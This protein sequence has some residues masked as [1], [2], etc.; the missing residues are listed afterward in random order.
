MMSLSESVL[1]LLD[2][3]TYTKFYLTFNAHRV[4]LST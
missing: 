4:T 3:L 1:E 2:F